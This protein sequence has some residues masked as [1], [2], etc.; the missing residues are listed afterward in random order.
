MTTKTLVFQPFEQPRAAFAYGKTVALGPRSPSPPPL[1]N[2]NLSPAQTLAASSTDSVSAQS[3]PAPKRRIQPVPQ[4]PAQPAAGP[5]SPKLPA[6]SRALSVPVDRG[7]TPP[8]LKPVGLSSPLR[9]HPA[10]PSRSSPPSESPASTPRA[11]GA[12]PSMP[13]PQPR[14]K[15]DGHLHGDVC[16]AWPERYRDISKGAAGLF[17]G[18]MACYVNATLQV[19]L[20]TPPVLAVLGAHHEA[21]CV[22]KRI[23]KF[24]ATCALR[25]Q[26]G[27][28]WSGKLR[29]YRPQVHRD[30]SMIKKGFS[31]NRQ[32]DTHEFFRF[33]TDAFQT[34][35]LAGLPKDLPEATKHTS[36]VYKVYGGRVRSRVLCVTCRKPSDTYDHFLDLSLDVGKNAKNLA[37]LMEGFMKEDR[38]DGENKYHCDNC[39]KKSVATK[40]MRIAEAPPV[41][42]LHLKRFGVN[43]F[44]YN[45][46]IQKVNTPISYPPVLDIAPY[47]TDKT[48]ESRYRLF[49]VTSHHGSS[50]QYGHY[51]SYVLGPGNQWFRAD[52]DDVTPVPRGEAL[53]DHAAYLLSYIRIPAG[54]GAPAS[55]VAPKGTPASTPKARP[56]QVA[57][58]SSA[59]G[60]KRFREDEDESP[61]AKKAAINGTSS[62]GHV[63]KRLIGPVIPPELRAAADSSAE[64]DD[65]ASEAR[66]DDA[67]A[68]SAVSALERLAYDYDS[69]P[70]SPAASL[71]PSRFSY[72]SPSRPVFSPSKAKAVLKNG[73]HKLDKHERH[74]ER[75]AD[76]PGSGNW[77]ASRKAQGAPMPF[78]QGQGHGHRKKARQNLREHLGGRLGRMKGKGQ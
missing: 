20:H 30:L 75:D 14:R 38:L 71:A 1:L 44:A 77:K 13:A 54:A 67:A 41:L 28:H 62:N 32:E 11:R 35:A 70:S 49:A 50:M 74:R 45:G 39:K 56:A 31:R 73:K 36:W 6:A 19:V 29:A 17:N 66:D 59:V 8:A 12:G 48:A 5:S 60:T 72:D 3:S 57:A 55:P 34:S 51:T 53:N 78:A 21:D 40:S 4:P 7:A 47:V 37:G 16:T 46:R 43:P 61:V 63:E 23:N 58:P 69:K 26:A 25:D 65:E 42:T 15:A 10:G 27:Q 24:C 33:L 18:S 76:G 52:D 22:L 68:P 64:S 2:L 9:P